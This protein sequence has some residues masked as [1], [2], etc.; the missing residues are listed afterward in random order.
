MYDI[1]FQVGNH[2]TF[3]DQIANNINFK[4][5]SVAQFLRHTKKMYPARFF[6]LH[7]TWT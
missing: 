4:A 1:A 6:C 2:E 5:K 7:F 3:L